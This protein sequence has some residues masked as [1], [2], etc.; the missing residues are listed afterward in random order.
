MEGCHKEKKD[1]KIREVIIKN[2][3]KNR[4]KR[5]RKKWKVRV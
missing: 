3:C 5:R 1:Y 4:E 2:D